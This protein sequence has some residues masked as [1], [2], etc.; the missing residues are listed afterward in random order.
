M[1]EAPRRCVV[2]GF[3]R[4]ALWKSE[5]LEEHNTCASTMEHREKRDAER[6]ADYT[7]ET[8]HHCV[9]Q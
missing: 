9:L 8:R 7:S 6:C 1:T 2:I 4:I 5:R 3:G